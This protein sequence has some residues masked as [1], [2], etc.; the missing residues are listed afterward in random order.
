[1]AIDHGVGNAQPLDP[2]NLGQIGIGERA[3][4][5]WQMLGHGRPPRSASSASG[6]RR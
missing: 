1:M 3:D 5:E 6:S 4:L 2:G